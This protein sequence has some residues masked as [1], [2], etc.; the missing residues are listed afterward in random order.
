VFRDAPVPPT[1]IS[2]DH[3]RVARWR[4]WHALRRT[5]EKRPDLFAKVKLSAKELAALDGAEP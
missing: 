3:A 5:R 4:R 2:G 1:L